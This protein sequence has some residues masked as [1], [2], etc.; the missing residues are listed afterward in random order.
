MEPSTEAFEANRERGNHGISGH[1]TAF[2][3]F[4]VDESRDVLSFYDVERQ[5][6]ALYDHLNDLKLE[7]ALWET[8]KTPPPSK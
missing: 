1:A 5:I 2:A 3:G 7:I 4:A 6:L 8:H